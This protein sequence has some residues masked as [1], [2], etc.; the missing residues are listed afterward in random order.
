MTLQQRAAFL[1]RAAVVRRL[2][3][4]GEATRAG[5]LLQ[6]THSDLQRLRAELAAPARWMPPAMKD[7]YREEIFQHT[8]DLKKEPR[9]PRWQDISQLGLRYPPL[10]VK[11]RKVK[12]AK[13]K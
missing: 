13:N 11:R 9:V 2:Q 8:E 6:N 7:A 4:V 3:A 1:D 5:L 10:V 12:K